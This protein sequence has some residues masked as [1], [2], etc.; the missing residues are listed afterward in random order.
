MRHLEAVSDCPVEESANCIPVNKVIELAE[1]NPGTTF[2][3]WEMI[4]APDTRT[5]FQKLYKDRVY[6]KDDWVFLGELVRVKPTSSPA[7]PDYVRGESPGVEAGLELTFNDKGTLARVDEFPSK[8]RRFKVATLGRPRP[9]APPAEADED[10]VNVGG[11][12]R[13]SRVKKQTRRTQRKRRNTKR[14]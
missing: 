1:T 12:K 11:R 7:P 5:R 9:S 2:Y 13:G 8:D 14:R 10:P 6:W 4:L 3:R